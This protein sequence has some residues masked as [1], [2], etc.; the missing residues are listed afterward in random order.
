MI[1]NNYKN[2]IRLD[3]LEKYSKFYEYFSGLIMGIFN[4]G[5]PSIINIDTYVYSSMQG[6]LDSI[7]ELLGKGRINDSYALLR[8]YYDAVVINIY[9]N[10]Y[11]DD[12]KFS[13]DIEIEKIS[14]WVQGKK[15][16][17]SYKEM[18]EYIKKSDKTKIITDLL[19]KDSRYDEIRRRA[20]DHTHYNSYY[21]VLQND[22]EIFLENRPELMN[23]F[24]QDVRNLFVFHLAYLFY[25]NDSYMM[26][27]TYVECLEEGYTP[28]ENSQYFVAPLIQDIFD[29]EIKIWRPD[30]VSEIKKNTSMLLE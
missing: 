15:K 9:T 26:S 6:T 25:I 11:F 30:I 19:Y 22:G 10:L 5:I 20:N 24:L 23:C 12:H 14:K 17:P 7:R 2:Q 28:P 1:T 8:K 3:Q 29:S 13:N 18:N 4:Y 21:M 27:T 16:L